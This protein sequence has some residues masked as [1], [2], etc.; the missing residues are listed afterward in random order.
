MIK[1]L[2][3]MTTAFIMMMGAFPVSASTNAVPVDFIVIDQFGY[4]PDAQKVAVIRNPIRGI[5]AHLSFLPGNVYQIINEAT[6]ESVFQGS[7]IHMFAD[8]FASGDEIW[9]LDFSAVRAP[10]RYFVLDVSN[11]V[12]SFSFSVA[13]DVYN[14]V[15]KHA[16]RM[17][18]YQRVGFTKE[19]QFAGAGWA[20]GASHI[21]PGQDTQARC[22]FNQNDASTERDLSGGWYDAGDFNKYTPW[23]ARYIEE[24]LNAY[25]ERPAAFSDDYNI[26]ESGNGIPDI[27]DEAR[28]GMDHLLRLQNNDGSMISV[29]GLS[30]A[31]PPSAATGRSFYGR[32]NTTSAYAAAR[33]FAVGA[34]VFEDFDQAYANQLRDA[35][36][37]AWT[38]AEA[39]PNVL[40]QNNCANFNSVGLAS[41]GQEIMDDGTGARTENRLF[42]AVYMYEMTGNA[43][44][45]TIFNDNYRVLPL[46]AW[47]NFMDHYRTGQH[48]LF[49]HYMRMPD[50]DPAVVTA[51]RNAINTAFN[52]TGANGSYAGR[53]N[54]DGYRSYISD[55][56]WA[57]NRVKSEYGYTFY[58]FAKSGIDPANA[59]RNLNAAEDY[60]HYIHGVN[61]FNWVYLTNMNSYGASRSITSIFHEWFHQGSPRW[62]TVGVST[63]GPAPG[64][65]SGG[66]NQGFNVQSGFPNSLGGYQP[67]AAE[68]TLGT[69]IQNVL[70]GSPPAKMYM[71]INHSWPINTWEITEPHI[72]YQVAYIRLLSKYVQPYDNTQPL[73]G[74]ADGNGIINSADVTLLRRYLAAIYKEAFRNENTFFA[75]NADVNGDNI[76]TYDD[77]TLL[78][79]MIAR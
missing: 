26:P 50:A 72:G 17:L 36:T 68:L 52:R 22:F 5:D 31:S 74:D 29:V 18:F 43:L 25:R 75:D 39:N 4:R 49:F 8:D 69:F 61:P 21:R 11:N 66:P 23:T 33:A 57:S 24:L 14:E 71:D 51:I 10:G 53:I 1:K 41:G 64:Y 67:T 13:E 46:F 20:D 27:I 65:L 73:R 47:Y 63:Y 32:V 58:Y 28:W 60:L 48:L 34:I 37:K 54:T 40:F 15:L 2:L 7:P 78:R 16:V 55:Y 30:H 3:S 12:R 6:G 9:W 62:C 79:W 76:I 45:L 44:Y 38:W 42:A 70:V 77:V 56:P 59:H 19:A 35:A